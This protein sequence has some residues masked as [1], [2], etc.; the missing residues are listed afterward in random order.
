MV[1]IKVVGLMMGIMISDWI[2]CGVFMTCSFSIM[3]FV[4]LVLCSA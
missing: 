1:V 3:S 2:S 4:I